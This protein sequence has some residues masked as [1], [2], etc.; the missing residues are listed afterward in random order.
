MKHQA[1]AAGTTV[2]KF[3]E[4]RFAFDQTGSSANALPQALAHIS[5][6]TE[7]ARA[8]GETSIGVFK[9]FGIALVDASGN[10]RDAGVVLKEFATKIATIKNPA[11]QASKVIA[12]FGPRIGKDL[13]SGLKAGTVGLDAFAAD[14]KRLGGE[15]TEEQV[16]IA[17]AFQAQAG[18]SGAAWEGTK[19]RLAA[20]FQGLFTPLLGSL[21]EAGGSFNQ[22]LDSIGV[23]SG[24]ITEFGAAAD[25]ALQNVANAF[26]TLEATGKQSIS[27]LDFQKPKEEID[28]AKTAVD[29]LAGAVEKVD[30]SKAAAPIE[31][32]G[33]TAKSTFGQIDEA[34]KATSNA[35]TDAFASVTGINLTPFFTVWQDT[36][37]QV[38]GSAK[39]K[40]AEIGPAVAASATASIQSSV[41]LVTPLQAKAADAVTA[42]NT[43]FAQADLSGIS[44]A[45]QTAAQGIQDAFAAIDF[46]TVFQTVVD[47]ANASFSQLPSIVQS[48]TS[49]IISTMTEVASAISG[50]FI[51]PVAQ[52]VQAF[53]QL[54]SAGT[55]AANTIKTSMSGIVTLLNGVASAAN[56]A[57]SA[58]E[59]MARAAAAA[60]SAARDATAAAAGRAR[61]GAVFSRGGSVWGAGT[62]TSDSI[63]AWLSHGEWVIKAAAVKKYGHGLFAMLNSMR[64]PASAVG[65]MLA[66]LRGFAGGGPV[67]LS[68]MF[69]S[70]RGGSLPSFATGG[71]VSDGAR[72]TINLSIGGQSFDGMIA[73]KEVADKLVRFAL[74]EQVK[75]GGRKPSWYYGQRG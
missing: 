58:F 24:N 61:G 11:E 10:A 3:Q 39:T 64:M 26:K 72:Q 55:S 40:G 17:D 35:I 7:Q 69:S 63:P 44:T 70:L 59:N 52:G 20:V 62:G 1:D 34:A 57:A 23:G 36:F 60:A 49:S 18:R 37:D 56:A 6:A 41:D 43:Q 16:K 25:T 22:F 5:Q 66:D 45:A 27:V 19:N 75:S 51:G 73:P 12:E 54:G 50:I 53:G 14:F 67:D 15:V 65:R 71:N 47:A 74:N 68:H 30:A 31:A 28:S 21:A 13:V 4:L 42:V 2:A 48:A 9:Q 29:N 32:L 33:T 38:V 46:S 8:S